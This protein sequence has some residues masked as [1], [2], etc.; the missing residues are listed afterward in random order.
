MFNSLSKI[1]QKI[2]KSI[3]RSI[4]D[5]NYAEAEEFENH[6]LADIKKQTKVNKVDLKAF[7]AKVKKVHISYEKKY[8]SKWLD[9]IKET[10]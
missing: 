2:I 5:F 10:R 3:G 8:G 9:L 1:E 7:K 6:Y 4:T